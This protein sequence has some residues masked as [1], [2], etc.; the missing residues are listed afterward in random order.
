MTTN[1]SLDDFELKFEEPKPKTQ[2]YSLQAA[3]PIIVKQ[4]IKRKHFNPIKAYF[5]YLFEV[6]TR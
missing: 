4:S 2:K 5:N 3:K 6:I 1:N